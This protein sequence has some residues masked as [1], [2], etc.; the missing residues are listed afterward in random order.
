MLDIQLLRD[1]PKSVATSLLTRGFKFD[2]ASFLVLEEKRKSLQVSTQALQNERNLRSKAIGE[3][4]ARGEDIE[5]MRAEVNRLAQELEQKK[6][7]LDQLLEQI[8]A[9]ALSMPNIPH[10]SVPLGSSEADNKEVRRWGK[11]KSFDFKVKAHDELGEALGQMDF[12]L[13]SKI[14]GSRFVVMKNQIA[15]L[16]RALIQFMLDN[17]TLHYQC[18]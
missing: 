2:V 10:D 8:E 1:N 4:K 16:H 9:I 5:P 18:R 3:A 12:A 14:T 17:H 15:R 11:P 13:A 6:V 7:E